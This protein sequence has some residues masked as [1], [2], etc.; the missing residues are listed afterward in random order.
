[1]QSNVRIKIFF[2]IPVYPKTRD[3]TTPR[4]VFC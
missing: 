4:L 2:I 3:K 1:M